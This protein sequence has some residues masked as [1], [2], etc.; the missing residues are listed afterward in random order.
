[1]KSWGHDAHDGPCTRP[2]PA[3]PARVVPHFPCYIRESF[4]I[5]LALSLCV[6]YNAIRCR[7]RCDCALPRIPLLV[8]FYGKSRCYGVL[9]RA[10]A[11]EY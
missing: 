3:F 2:P 10:C 11:A 1:M 7:Q 5:I 8:A 4:H 6:R 9:Y